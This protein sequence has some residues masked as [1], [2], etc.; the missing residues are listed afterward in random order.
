MSLDWSGGDTGPGSMSGKVG[1]DF[2]TSAYRKEHWRARA[3]T[4]NL[5]CRCV[6]GALPLGCNLPQEV[7]REER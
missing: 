7:T 5:S 4:S 3:E 2:I 1:N 6:G